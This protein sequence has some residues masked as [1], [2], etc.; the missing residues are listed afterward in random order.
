MKNDLPQGWARVGFF[1]F[2]VLQRGYDLPLSKAKPGPYPILTSAGIVAYNAEFKAR[3]P[4]VVTGRSGS[5]GRVFYVDSDYWPHNTALYVRDFNGSEPKFVYYFLR[6]FDIRQYSASTAVPTLN[7]NNL[8]DVFVNIPPLAEQRRIVEKLDKLLGKL[9]LCQHRLDHI[10]ALLKRLRQS[11][12]A[13]ACSGRLTAAWREEHTH[14]DKIDETL[15]VIS[16]RRTA[17]AKSPTLSKTIRKIFSTSEENDSDELPKGWRFIR[18]NKLSESFDYGT[19]AKSQSTGA[20]P[21]LRMGNIQNGEIDWTNLLYTSDDEEIEKYSLSPNAVLFNR[22]NSPELVGKTAIYR[23]ERPAIFAGYLIRINPIPELDPEYL[24]L[25]LNTNYAKDFYSG[26]KTDGVSQSNINAQK[27]GNFEV[28]FCTLIEQLEIVRR[29]GTMFALADRIEARYMEA[30]K[31]VT[32]LGQSILSKA[33]DGELVAQDPHEEPASIFLERIRSRGV[34]SKP[35]QS[36]MLRER[37]MPPITKESIRST[38]R[39]FPKE[40]FSFADLHASVGADYETLKDI[41]F[42]LLD[43]PIPCIHQVFDVKAQ[44]IRLRRLN[45]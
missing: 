40:T 33:L 11:I 31:R 23:G 43:E 19:S 38:I 9:E 15:A 29:V 30:Q 13:A 25:C 17:S 5:I 10:P 39:E 6:G 8:R 32:G 26:V 21:V 44:E 16:R 45:A 24:N 14:E 20:V 1:E 22:T 12:L 27:L 3:G 37:S 28:P 4:G 35:A 36:A 18:L 41:V 42:A 2:C 7:R 34:T